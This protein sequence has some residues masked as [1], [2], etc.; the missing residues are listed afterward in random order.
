MSRHRD[1]GNTIER[2]PGGF[3]LN[4]FD[5]RPAT[6]DLMESQGLGGGG[7]TWLGLLTAALELESPETLT[8][9]DLDDEPD[10]LLVTAEERAPLEIVQTYVALLMSD[11][12]FLRLCLDHARDG[13]YLE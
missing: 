12:N 6:L 3:F 7:H 9:I 11:E 1:I 5:H 4:V 13:G 2:H 8:Q 10:L